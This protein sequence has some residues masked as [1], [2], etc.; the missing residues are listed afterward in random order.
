MSPA[1]PL[2]KRITHL[3]IHSW[4]KTLCYNVDTGDIEDPTGKYKVVLNI[5]VSFFGKVTEMWY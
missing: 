4:W 2:P 3:R 5:R 1:F